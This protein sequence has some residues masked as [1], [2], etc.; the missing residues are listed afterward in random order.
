MERIDI[1]D[2]P[3]D[4]YNGRDMI[5]I[6]GRNSDR[7]TRKAI[8]FFKEHRFDFQFVDLDSRDLSKREWEAV[9]S[10]V[11]DS[12]DLIDKD[13]KLFKKGGYQWKEYNPLEEV[14]LNPGLL[15][16]PVI[17]DKNKA[18]IGFDPVYCKELFKCN[19]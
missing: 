9:A 7:E 3:V 17:R 16:I 8:M 15:R 6:I 10:C 1:V 5:Q 14:I 11:E 2:N 19:I 12:S 18:R 4:Y 13:S